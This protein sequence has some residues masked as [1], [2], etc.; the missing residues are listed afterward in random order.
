MAGS[1]Q[2]SD[3]LRQLLH[4]HDTPEHRKLGL[5]MEAAEG[6]V[7][8]MQRA[9]RAVGITAAFSLA[10]LGYCAVL[11]PSYFDSTMPLAVRVLRILCLGCGLSFLS[12]WSMSRY[13]GS[14][15]GRLQNQ[16]RQLVLRHLSSS[17]TQP[18]DPDLDKTLSRSGT[19][20]GEERKI[21]AL[22]KAS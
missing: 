10:G 18:A 22:P 9:C 20:A 5:R 11:L 16:A 17:R 4:L 19:S 1:R 15:L 3:F 14:I 13:Y 2:Q 6:D 21:I 12:F 8:A 7:R